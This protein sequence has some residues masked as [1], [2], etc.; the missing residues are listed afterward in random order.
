MITNDTGMIFKGFLVARTTNFDEVSDSSG[1][2]PNSELSPGVAKPIHQV[3]LSLQRDLGRSHCMLF[4]AVSNPR[5]CKE[6]K[7]Y[8]VSYPTAASP[9]SIE[10]GKSSS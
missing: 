7:E 9:G 3:H 10:A 1:C 6:A 8:G 4:T 2:S 5:L